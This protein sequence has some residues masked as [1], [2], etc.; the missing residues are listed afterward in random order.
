MRRANWHGDATQPI[1]PVCATQST[2]APRVHCARARVVSARCEATRSVAEKSAFAKGV[3]CIGVE[4]TFIFGSGVFDPM[5][6]K[7]SRQSQL[8]D[9]GN[10]FDL[11]L[12]ASSFYAQLAKAAPGLFKDDDFAMFYHS[13]RGRPSVPPSLLAL[14]TILK[15]HDQVS[16]EETVA[17]SAYDL[18][19]AAVLGLPA[20]R[21]VCAKSTFQLF[22][23]HLIIHE[24]VRQIFVKSIEEAKK[25]GLLKGTLRAATDTKPILGRGAVLDTYNLLGEAIISLARQLAKEKSQSLDDY[26]HEVGMDL[27][28]GLSLKG[29]ADIDWSDEQA[30]QSLL[31][32]IVRDARTLLVRANGGSDEVRKAAELLSQILMQDVEDKTDG[33]D[34]PPSARIKRGTTPGRVLSVTDPEQRHGH[35]SSSNRFNGSKASVVTDVDSQIIVGAVVLPGDAPDNQGALNQIKMAEAN[36]GMTVSETFAD[37][38]YGDGGTRKEFEDAGRVLVAKVPKAPHTD[39]IF[40]KSRFLIDLENYTVTCPAGN[41]SSKYF[42]RGAVKVFSFAGFCSSC[43]LKAQCTKSASSRRLQVH[44]QERLLQQARAYQ[45]T[46]D[47]RKRLRDRITVEHTLARLSHLGI[48]QARYIGLVKTR[49]QLLM[50]CTVAN[51]RRVWNWTA[52]Q[53]EQTPI[54]APA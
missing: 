15:E 5:I 38:A 25:S 45:K 11:E 22:R 47:G 41:T 3:F 7:R 36:S 9:V 1:P 29:S 48:G 53:N 32:R 44:P 51:L 17:R 33:R 6:G 20:G 35:K 37:C 19:W 43:P 27:Y 24:A 42:M 26:L 34:A 10:V 18:R 13:D 39:G 50:A 31:N 23:A 52:S 2:A 14:M 8:F 54:L 46:E 40:P 4:S 12:P 49:Y 30:R 28:A 21:Q 16:D